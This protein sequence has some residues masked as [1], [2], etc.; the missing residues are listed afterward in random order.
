MSV[1]FVVFYPRPPFNVAV[2]QLCLLLLGKTRAPFWLD[3]APDPFP[4]L[5][6]HR[7]VLKGSNG[8]D[9]PMAL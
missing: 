7:V 5:A 3:P 8:L 2:S 4:V 9:L 1:I 6:S